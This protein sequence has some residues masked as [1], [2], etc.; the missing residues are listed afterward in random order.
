MKKKLFAVIIILLFSIENV[1]FNYVI[2]AMS[3]NV[4]IVSISAMTMAD[5]ANPNTPDGNP[6]FAVTFDKAITDKSFIFVNASRSFI[7]ANGNFGKYNANDLDYIESSGAKS[8]ILNKIILDGK[9][10][11]ELMALEPNDWNR[12]LTIM[13]HANNNKLDFYFQNNGANDIDIN[14]EHTIEFL[15]GFVS[16]NGNILN[17][18]QIFKF[19]PSK[20]A[21]VR[22]FEVKNLSPVTQISGF[23]TFNIEFSKSAA[24]SDV[25]FANTT[26]DNVNTMILINGKTLAQMQAETNNQRIVDVHWNGVNGDVNNKG[27][28]FYFPQTNATQYNLKLD[29]TDTIKL[30][31]GLISPNNYILTKDYEFT[32][33]PSYNLWAKGTKNTTYTDTS[34]ANITKITSSSG[35]KNFTI[36]FDKAVTNKFMPHINGEFSWLRLANTALGN[37][38]TEDDFNAIILNGVHQSIQTKIKFDGKTISQMMNDEPNLTITNTTV[39]TH[40]NENSLN[41]YFDEKGNNNFDINQNHTLEI[42]SGFI[43]PNNCIVENT[44]IYIYDWKLGFWYNSD[45]PPSNDFFKIEAINPINPINNLYPISIRFDKPTTD[46]TK[47][48]DQNNYYLQNY[49]LINN[50]PIKEIIEKSS[51]DQSVQIHWSPDYT[52]RQSLNIYLKEE[53]ESEFNVKFDGTDKIKFLSGFRCPNGYTLE[54]DAEYIYKPL[55]NIWATTV[56]EP[57]Y[58]PINIVN[59]TSI[60][61]SSAGVYGFTINFDGEIV[62]KFMPHINADPSWLSAVNN[63]LGKPYTNEDLNY[64][65]ASGVQESILKNIKFDDKTIYEL[66]QNETDVTQRPVTVMVNL[67]GKAMTISFQKKNEIKN[68]INHKLTIVDGLKLP[69]GKMISETKEFTY[70]EDIGGWFG[71]GRKVSEQAID[72]ESLKPITLINGLY[73]FQIKFDKSAA[74]FEEQFVSGVGSLRNKLLINGKTIEYINENARDKD[75]KPV[76]KAV[77]AH[78]MD[79]SGDKYY[80]LHLFVKESVSNMGIKLDG[81][82]TIEILDG[83]KTP[84]GQKIFERTVFRYDNKNAFW[85]NG[86]MKADFEEM[87]AIFVSDF[88]KEGK[89]TSF[90]ITFDKPITSIQ[91]PHINASFAWLDA[92]SKQTIPPFRYNT[93]MLNHLGKLE[94][95]KRVLENIV[96]NGKTIEEYMKNETNINLLPV[97]VMVHYG[98][99]DNDSMYISFSGEGKNKIEDTKQ[100]FTLE[101]KNGLRGTNLYETKND[102]SFVYDYNLGK[103]ESNSSTKTTVLVNEIP[104]NLSPILPSENYS[105]PIIL[106]ILGV[107]LIAFFTVFLIIKRNKGGIK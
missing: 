38:Y 75:G 23:N 65:I 19:L 59:V 90:Y 13:M 29:G 91:F 50:I 103:W 49:I 37:P 52:G 12:N 28:N 35:L 41:V 20:N 4:K 74:D 30:S 11:A 7:E 61:E 88:I 5:D 26:N 56:V 76:E 57:N 39:M 63:N 16:L 101:L 46:T 3:E 36:N 60:K 104:K 107:I 66:M 105:I 55:S 15:S 70:F 72:V 1:A 97:T 53:L 18:G 71:N 42:A 89:N 9:S 47:T 102:Q 94:I 32:Y 31:K 40:Y 82:D 79:N 87:K 85:I 24:N 62:G 27:L 54:K 67:S 22:D 68:S 44:T 6:Y 83:F 73:A 10:I 2:N 58:T 25:L 8:S 93:T 100:N 78:W 51:I 64:I 14:F 92:I 45:S 95:Q 34:I 43:T 80:V 33:K 77:Q 99:P 98:N 48:F 21:W 86:E 106:A 81:K 84:K 17:E 69:S 96:F